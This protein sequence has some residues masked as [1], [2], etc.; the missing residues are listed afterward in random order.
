MTKSILRL[1]ALLVASLLWAACAA[2]TAAPEGSG[3]P[4]LPRGAPSTTDTGLGDFYYLTTASDG[5]WQLRS[6]KQES[7]LSASDWFSLSPDGTQLAVSVPPQPGKA[8]DLVIM[9]LDGTMQAHVATSIWSAL[10]RPGTSD[11]LYLVRPLER[12][13]AWQWHVRSADGSDRLLLERETLDTLYADVSP[14]GKWLVYTASF[15]V[16]NKKLWELRAIDIDSGVT[17]K[18]YEG[19]GQGVFYYRWYGPSTISFI[20]EGSKEVVLVALPR[21]EPQVYLASEASLH[22]HDWAPGG[23]R[24]IVQTL[25][26]GIELWQR[27]GRA[28][29]CEGEWKPRGWARSGRYILLQHDKEKAFYMLEADRF[30]ECRPQRIPG[31]ARGDSPWHPSQDSILLTIGQTK[32]DRGELQLWAMVPEGPKLLKSFGPGFG[33]EWAVTR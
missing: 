27:D 17:H 12:K 32:E 10:W 2:P 23:G 18:F 31:I 24:V 6:T 13:R 22:T 8:G 30:A 29:R 25:P 7:P 21:G 5:M 4:S 3:T 26:A 14:D 19:R 9:K 16:N 15:A 1:I 11:I 28:S 20:D 33:V